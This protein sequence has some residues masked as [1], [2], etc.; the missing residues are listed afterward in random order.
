MK[1]RKTVYGKNFRKPFSKTKHA[2]SSSSRPPSLHS[3]SRPPSLLS[4][5]DL[6]L[7]SLLSAVPPSRATPSHLAVPSHPQPP[8]PAPIYF[9]HGKPP[10]LRSPSLTDR[11]RSDQDQILI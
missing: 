6:T 9:S 3:S 5:L 10:P 2:R 11:I 4:A 7:C 8:L 1:K